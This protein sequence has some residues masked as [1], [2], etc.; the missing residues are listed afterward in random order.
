MVYTFLIKFIMRS[1][2][3]ALSIKVVRNV[4]TSDLAEKS[5]MPI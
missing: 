5:F 3:S 2:L 4:L 1:L